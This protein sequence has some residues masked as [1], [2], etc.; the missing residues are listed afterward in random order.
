MTAARGWR[1]SN[2]GMIVV[3]SNEPM[4]LDG[5][6]AVVRVVEAG[7]L[8]LYCVPV[9]RGVAAG[10]RRVISRLG[11]G[12]AVFSVPMPVPHS[13]RLG[14]VPIGEASVRELSIDDLWAERTADSAAVDSMVQDWVDLMVRL[15]GS[16]NA[17]KLGHRVGDGGEI[18]L[19]DGEVVCGR[20]RSV[21]WGRVLSGEVHCAG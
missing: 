12:R 15:L 6:A 20:R 11:A 17:P 8:A 18:E 9:R 5:S 19:D 4:I 2:S 1:R 10:T 13:L 21:C 14:V 7:S 3:G 16:E